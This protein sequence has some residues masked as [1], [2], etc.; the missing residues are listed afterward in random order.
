MLLVKTEMRT[1]MD[2]AGG[3]GKKQRL[4]MAAA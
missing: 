4:G 2:V 1:T 3:D